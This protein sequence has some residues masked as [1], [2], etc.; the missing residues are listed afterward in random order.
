MRYNP[1]Q[2]AVEYNKNH[3]R[4]RRWHQV[5]SVMASIVVFCTTYALILPAITMEDLTCTVTEHSHGPECYSEVTEFVCMAEEGEGH[6]HDGR[7]FKEVDRL[8]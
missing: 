3:R 6:Q 5:V 2:K 8:A 1:L 7:C 4:N